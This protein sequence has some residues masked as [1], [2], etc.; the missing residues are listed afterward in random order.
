MGQDGRA[1]TASAGAVALSGW[2]A[3]VGLGQLLALALVLRLAVL[4]IA[5]PAH[6][7]EVFQYLETAH[8]L[9]FGH[10]VVTWEWRE[11]MRGW[12]MPFLVA[13]PMWLGDRLAPGS[14]LYLVLPK[15]VMTLASLGA[16]VVGWRMGAQVSR[17]HA[18]VAGF[19]A[20]IWF[21]L[22][23][24]APH[25]MSETAGVV[26]ILPAA[27]LLVDRP[28]WTFLRLASAA[29]LLTVA[30][31]I[32]FQYG[33]AVVALVIA[34]CVVDVRRCWLP[35]LV[36]GVVGLLPSVV[37]DL[38]MGAVPFQ[39]VIENVRLNLVENR[40]ASFSSSGPLGY[41]PEI[42]PRMALWAVPLVVLAGLGARR[43]PALAWMAV[44]NLVFHSLIAHK[45]YR[46]ILLT[47]FTAVL[48]AA[49]GTVDWVN[50]EARVKGPRA[51][52]ARLR[53]LLVVW[54]VASLSCASG[55]FRSQWLKFRP[56]M[57][58]ATQ[59]RADPALCGLAVYRHDWSMTGGYAY[60]HRN[61]PMLL[62]YDSR[63]PAADLAAT[64]D[65]F[66]TI[67]TS[68]DRAPELPAAF[69]PLACEG[70]G[71]WRMCLYRRP[72]PCTAGAQNFE[73]STVLRR[74]GQ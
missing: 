73:I 20:A 18:Q 7:D 40:A 61:T 2:L 60:L 11:G 72:G 71:P 63:H 69:A 5:T 33:P 51:G 36:G 1:E 3:R 17:L 39:W 28:R 50:H 22:V 8:R 42:W 57:Q 53:F 9:L 13:G 21:D 10:G 35:V 46:F 23:Y 34:A 48:L 26:L 31:S 66:N 44:V 27:W 43:Y 62:F 37:S 55:G 38:A 49:L 12:L 14:G 25:A 68:P 29:A 47:T 32:R 58:L 15:L 30:V 45:E 24:F 56:E 6:P 54:L 70:R 16:V 52:R 4:T 65:G 41:G 74:I 19:V 67:M 59:L 64:T